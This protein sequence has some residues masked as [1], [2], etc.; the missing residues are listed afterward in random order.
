LFED[1]GHFVK[2]LLQY[3]VPASK[4]TTDVLEASF[5]ASRKYLLVNV[6][7]DFNAPKP[8][9]DRKR[10]AYLVFNARKR[11]LFADM[12]NILDIF[13]HTS[14][15]GGMEKYSKLFIYLP[16]TTLNDKLKFL[17]DFCFAVDVSP[18]S[19][20]LNSK[21]KI[22]VVSNIH[23]LNYKT[24]NS[25]ASI[26]HHLNSKIKDIS[27]FL[28][29]YDVATVIDNCILKA[30]HDQKCQ[31]EFPT[32][33]RYEVKNLASVDRVGHRHQ[34]GSKIAQSPNLASTTLSFV[35]KVSHLPFNFVSKVIRL[36]IKKQQNLSSTFTRHAS[37]N[38]NFS[39]EDSDRPTSTLHETS[40]RNHVM[41]PTC[42]P[43]ILPCDTKVM[44]Q[45]R[46]RSSSFNS[47]LDT[48]FAHL[49]QAALD[50]LSHS[51]TSCP[52]MNEPV[53]YD[54]DS[55][56]LNE[57]PVQPSWL[58]Y[59]NSEPIRGCRTQLWLQ[60]NPVRL[61]PRHLLLAKCVCDGSRCAKNGPH[62]CITI[63]VAVVSLIRDTREERDQAT[64]VRRQKEM[65][66]V[67]CVCSEQKSVLLHENQPNIL[68]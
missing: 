17:K 19:N 18:K 9:I 25:V 24:K 49:P 45:A 44:Q 34:A 32:T 67:G 55:P 26:T 4:C 1:H 27:A 33:F 14:L 42:D 59:E 43:Q 40:L 65:L 54:I 36:L 22:F 35:N 5:T 15:P 10:L 6:L 12:K 52:D 39:K 31:H 68:V 66:P 61:W 53:I 64:G 58:P 30:Q 13:V 38:L 3:I 23:H 41:S 63:K 60:I 16:V 20:N 48:E 62:K 51:S 47:E 46:K 57:I 8:D 28:K 11:L 56:I 21:S 37:D 29:V 2:H 50:F 7:R